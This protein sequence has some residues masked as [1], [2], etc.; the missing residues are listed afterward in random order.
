MVQRKA[1]YKLNNGKYIEGVMERATSKS[2]DIVRRRGRN[3]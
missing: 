1:A 2:R 3:V